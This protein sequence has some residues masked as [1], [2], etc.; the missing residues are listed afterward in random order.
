MSEQL[1]NVKQVV[2]VTGQKTVN[3]YLELG[4]VV[5]NTVAEREGEAGWIKYSLGWPN[6]LPVKKPNPMDF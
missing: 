3:A 4:W 6:D 1:Q 5:L 2:E